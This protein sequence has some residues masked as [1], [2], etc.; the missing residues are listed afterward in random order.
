MGD[1]T[2]LHQPGIGDEQRPVHSKLPREMTEPLERAMSEHHASARLKIEWDH[3][4]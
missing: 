1:I 2:G 4:K 3:V